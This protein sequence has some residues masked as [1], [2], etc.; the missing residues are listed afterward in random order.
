MTGTTQTEVIRDPAI[1]GG[2]PTVSGTHILAETIL[3][4]LRADS[5]ADEVFKGY[6][7]VEIGLCDFND[8]QRS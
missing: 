3:S 4:Y 2:E 8:L 5:T 6:P 1:M 7:H